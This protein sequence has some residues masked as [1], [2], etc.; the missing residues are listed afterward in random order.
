MSPILPAA[1]S[2]RA[3]ASRFPAR[4]PQSPALKSTGDSYSSIPSLHLSSHTRISPLYASTASR[5]FEALRRPR[6]PLH[7]ICSRLLQDLVLKPSEVR[8]ASRLNPGT[9][10][11][12][13]QGLDLGGDG[14]SIPVRYEG[15]NQRPN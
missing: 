14:E 11:S 15:H 9:T 3:Q 12:Q 7:F 8:G 5:P 10:R 6:M 4:P 13:E 1:V 2:A